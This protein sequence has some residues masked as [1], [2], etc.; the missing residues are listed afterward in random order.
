MWARPSKRRTVTGKT[1][2]LAERPQ[3]I[4]SLAV[5]PRKAR[6]AG[7]R[8]RR[9]Q[10]ADRRPSGGDGSARNRRRD[11]LVRLLRRVV[12]ARGGRPSRT[13]S[14]VPL[15]RARGSPEAASSTGRPSA[16]S[17]SSGAA[18]ATGGR[19][20]SAS[21]PAA[22]RMATSSSS[23]V[24]EAS[25]SASGRS[26]RI[27]SSGHRGPEN[28]PLPPEVEPRGKSGVVRGTGVAVASGELVLAE[29]LPQLVTELERADRHLQA[30]TAFGVVVG[31]LPAANVTAGGRAKKIPCGSLNLTAILQIPEWP[32]HQSP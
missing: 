14:P 12:P 18:S 17:W 4:W 23:A 30:A 7:D 29:N 31:T 28:V 2:I 16:A 9:P 32:C 19:V 24:V 5:W 11:A 6:P 13:T 1:D 8:R 20:T 10:P 15:P 25:A 27:G 26:R 22:R 3:G 21:T